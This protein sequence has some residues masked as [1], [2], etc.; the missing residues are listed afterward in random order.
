MGNPTWEYDDGT[1]EVPPG[2]VDPVERVLVVGAGAAG[3]T[4]ANALTNAGVECLVLEARDRVGGRLHTVNLGGGWVDVGGSWLHNLET[5]PLRRFADQVGVT[6]RD[7]DAFAEIVAYDP[8]ESRLLTDDEFFEALG[9]FAGFA[10]QSKALADEL[11]DGTSAA[12]GI[13]AYLARLDLDPNVARRA[14]AVIRA[15]AEAE[16]ASTTEKTSLRWLFNGTSGDGRSAFGDLAE[17]GYVSLMSALASGLDVRLGAVV[18]DVEYDSDGVVVRMGNGSAERG[19]H[20]VVTVPLGVLKHG[21]VTFTPPLP[22]TRAEAIDRLGFDRFEKVVMTF[23]EPFWRKADIGNL[24]LLPANSG[25][26][27]TVV[28]STDEPPT[29]MCLVYDPN[30][31]HVHGRPPAEAATWLLDK[32]SEAIGAPCPDPLEVIVTNWAADPFARGS[33]THV[34]P[35]ASFEDVEL[36]GDPV[37][38][39]LLFAGEGTTWEEMTHAGGAALTGIREAKRLLKTPTVRLGRVDPAPA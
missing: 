7:G 8:L 11:G 34:P 17:G 32:I 14:R 27:A 36:L 2:V 10:E 38:P 20:A 30:A 5:N 24:A 6:C 18:T 4:V 28:V 3:L 19:T 9:I 22:P 29:L 16:A 1:S 37:S 33:Y 25:E 21:S 15:A 39:R 26:T 12:E 23:P 13:D 31:D 35:G